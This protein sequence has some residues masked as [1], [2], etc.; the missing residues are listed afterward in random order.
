MSLSTLLSATALHVAHTKIELVIDADVPFPR[1]FA[2]LAAGGFV[3]EAINESRVLVS[4]SGST[5]EVEE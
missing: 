1:L 4:L 2:A 3:I 5:R